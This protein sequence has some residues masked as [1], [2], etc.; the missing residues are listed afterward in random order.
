MDRF[1]KGA[2]PLLVLFLAYAFLW[3]DF[4]LP[5]SPI[6]LFSTP[7][8]VLSALKGAART[9]ILLWLGKRWLAEDCPL[10]EKAL[11][12]PR[13]V[14]DG[15]GI[16]A[17]EAALA[18]AGAL[19]ALAAGVENPLLAFFPHAAAPNPL[20][21]VFIVLACLGTGYSE[22]LFF[23]FFAVGALGRAGFAPAA[24]YLVSA[25]V[26]ALSHLGQGLYGA[27]MTGIFALVFSFFRI[28]GSKLH[29]LALGHAFYD[30][31]VLLVTAFT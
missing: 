13:E 26:F 21:L 17:C 9:A 20:S 3:P 8:F 1:K 11:P 12:Q 10:P 19:L 7:W 24:A 16:G 30:L 25:L 28:K 2:A 27:A 5:P 4:F 15:L 14:L 31:A 22:E 18:L 29:A 6:R 23:R